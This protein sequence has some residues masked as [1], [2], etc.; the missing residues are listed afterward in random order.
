MAPRASGFHPLTSEQC[1]SGRRILSACRKRRILAAC[2]ACA[3]TLTA[4]VRLGPLPYLGGWDALRFPPATVPGIRG[5][6]TGM[7]PSIVCSCRRSPPVVTTP[8][9][10]NAR[11]KPGRSSAIQQRVGSAP[12]LLSHWL[13]GL[14]GDGQRRTIGQDHVQYAKEAPSGSHH[15]L[16]DP[17]GA[18]PLALR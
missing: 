16:S 17:P 9:D 10:A 4:Q 5:R 7:A 11:R 2:F 12:R 14:R 3:R 18:D 8:V 13:G 6:F 1:A 15:R